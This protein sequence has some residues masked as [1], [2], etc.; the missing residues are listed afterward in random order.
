MR[1]WLPWTEVLVNS[2]EFHGFPSSNL[3]F[4]IIAVFCSQLSE[5]F[6][7]DPPR[8]SLEDHQCSDFLWLL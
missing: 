6:L 5:I 3:P 8:I 2:S 1:A 4:I 7:R